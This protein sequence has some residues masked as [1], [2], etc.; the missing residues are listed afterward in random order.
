M[1]LV[2]IDAGHY[3]I[4]KLINYIR[5]VQKETEIFQIQRAR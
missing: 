1:K 3:I 2:E 5:Y 4:F